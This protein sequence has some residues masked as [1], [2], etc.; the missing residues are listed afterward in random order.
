MARGLFAVR[1]GQVEMVRHTKAGHLVTPH[2][3]LAG[4]SFAEASLFS[5]KYHWDAVAQ[6][7]AEVIL[8]RT[9]P[10]LEQIASDPDFAQAG[11]ERFARQV[12]A[13]RR[14]PELLAIRPATDR[15]LA[16]LADQGQNGTVPSLAW[17][18]GLSHEATCRAL[19][20]L[21][22]EGKARKLERRRY[23]AICTLRG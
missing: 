6:A 5:V 22:A 15:G 12:Q 10:V 23:A 19:S 8:G 17:D 11:M 1:S 9:L 14:R 13:Y 2:R 3:A 4:E 16:A 20:A 18:V 7:A 21:A